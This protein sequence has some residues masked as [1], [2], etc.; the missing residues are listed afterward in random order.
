VALLRK[1]Y[2]YF[3]KSGKGKQGLKIIIKQLNDKRTTEGAL[4]IVHDPD[5]A[6]ENIAHPARDEP[7]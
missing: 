2:E 6:L 1:L 5:D 3:R 4:N 7:R